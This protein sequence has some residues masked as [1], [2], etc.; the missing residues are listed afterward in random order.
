ML[1]VGVYNLGFCAVDRRAGEFLDWWW[2]HLQTECLGDPTAGL[3]VDQKWVDIGSVLFR[4]GAFRHYGYNT[5]VA[6]LHERPIGFDAEGYYVTT[7]GDR[8]RL[9][10]FHAFD[11]DRPGRLSTRFEV[12]DS[13]DD[14]ALVAIYSLCQEYAG[15]I[16]RITADLPEVGDYPY[17]RDTTGKPISRHL[18]RA[19]RLAS[20]DADGGLPSPFL[21]SDAAAF[22]AWRRQARTQEARW[23]MTDVVKGVRLTFP[24]EYRRMKT[25]FPGVVRRFRGLRGRPTGIWH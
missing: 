18:R 8:L 16:K 6:N 23:L 24:E 12:V 14:P 15:L 2:G 10:H 4:A 19:Y 13:S 20:D 11:P 17:N 5:G 1:A 22:S 21:A 25:R 3:F 7:N 9:F